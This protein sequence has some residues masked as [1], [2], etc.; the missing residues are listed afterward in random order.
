MDQSTYQAIAVL[1][2]AENISL[3]A[4][5]LRLVLNEIL[6]YGRI[7]VKRAYG[8]WISS[9]LYRWK[10]YLIELAIEPI[11]VL[12]YVSGKNSSDL[13]MV[14]DA[15]DLLYADKYDAFVIVSSDSDFT[16]LAVRL[17]QNG[18]YVFG[19]GE[20]KTPQSMSNAC[21]NF[22]FIENLGI[23][24]PTG[25]ADDAA[26]SEQ[27]E[28]P[29]IEEL[30]PPLIQAWEKHQHGDGWASLADAG[31]IIKRLQPDFDPR[32]YGAKNLSGIIT[33]LSA[34]FERAL[35]GSKG[36]QYV[37]YRPKHQ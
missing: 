19:V 37:A 28:I 32:T 15:M 29:T 13:A 30:V 10:S 20:R 36:H 25:T 1:I 16:R 11:Q 18:V 21:D 5:A 35:R 7:V 22:I 17:K 27:S 31:Q 34:N 12:P 6:E 23:H 2:D 14:I 33:K 4:D 9:N 26:Q 8:N 24:P 3:Q